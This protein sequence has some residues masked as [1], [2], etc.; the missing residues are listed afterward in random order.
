MHNGEMEY[1]A[2]RKYKGFEE[3]KKFMSPTKPPKYEDIRN[4]CVPIF[5][6][7]MLQIL[8][9][10]H[11]AQPCPGAHQASYPVGTR[12]DFHKSKVAEE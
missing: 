11:K 7:T 4:M 5:I 3:L 1:L 8:P 9:L 2:L 10:L 6:T 12:V